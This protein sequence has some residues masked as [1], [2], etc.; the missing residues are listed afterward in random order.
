[1]IDTIILQIQIDK[2][3]I[4]DPSQ[5]K[6]SA[7]LLFENYYGFLKCVNNPT[8]SGRQKGTY[9]P[10][11]TTIRRGGNLYLKAEFSTPKLLLGNN[12]DEI[13]EIDF[14]EMVSKLREIIE[15]MGVRLWTHE[16]ENAEVIAFHPSKNIPLSNGYTSSFA[17]RELSKIDLTEKMDIEQVKFRNSGELLGIYSNRHSV[18][19]YDKISDLN[20][21]A[22]R[23]IDKDQ[24]KQ[25]FSLFDYIKRERQQLEVLRFEVRLSNRKKMKEILER[26][27]FKDT[28][29]FKNIFKKVLCQKILNLYWEK[30]FR[31]DLFLFSVNNKSQKILQ[32]ILMRYPKTKIKTAVFMTG[33]NSLCKDDDGIRGFRNIA[34]NYRPKTNWIMLKNHLRKFKDDIFSQ[35][36]HG[37]IKDIEENLDKFE[38]FNI[39]NHKLNSS[40][41]DGIIK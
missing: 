3:A 11:L 10:R 28:P 5:F 38:S 39:K 7:R 33:L 41:H 4:T 18:V 16:I 27:N 35:P 2:S 12:L 29:L 31:K 9:K 22:K 15:G 6:P 23:A 34:K 25:Q 36:A 21:P 14:D 26:V 30:Y 20:K 40:T 8:A 24:T 13:E 32:Q 19:F 37:F 1:M 17:I